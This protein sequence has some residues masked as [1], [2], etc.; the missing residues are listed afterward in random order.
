MLKFQIEF[1]ESLLNS[2]K[3]VLL[4]DK[5]YSFGS[6]NDHL[7]IRPYHLPEINSSYCQVAEI[8]KDSVCNR[9][10]AY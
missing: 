3:R 9:S 8:K 2:G 6:V 1:I 4:V 10:Y 5:D 7:I